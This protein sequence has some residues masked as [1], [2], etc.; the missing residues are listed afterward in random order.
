M[1]DS[2]MVVV[3]LLL[4]Q[5]VGVVCLLVIVELVVLLVVMFVQ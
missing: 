3:D 5:I 2:G 4:V 1:F